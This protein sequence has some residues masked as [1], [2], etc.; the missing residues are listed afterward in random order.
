MAAEPGVQGP[1]KATLC[2]LKCSLNNTS[3]QDVHS[4]CTDDVKMFWVFFLAAEVL[5]VFPSACPLWWGSE[6][7]LSTHTHE[8][9][10]Q[11]LTAAG[12]SYAFMGCPAALPDYKRVKVQPGTCTSIK[13]TD[14]ICSEATTH[15]SEHSS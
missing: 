2:S 7:E 10:P 11:L 3:A 15:E 14:C 9:T 4:R 12:F 13:S 8:N 5:L 6:G 1:R